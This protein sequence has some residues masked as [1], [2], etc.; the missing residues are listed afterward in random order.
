M[1]LHLAI[2][3]TILSFVNLTKEKR[4]AEYLHIKMEGRGRDREVDLDSRQE[5]K[6]NLNV[7]GLN[8]S[9]LQNVAD[10]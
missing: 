9:A 8:P 2:K 5:N 3:W 6:E 10:C 4:R 1:P 7:L